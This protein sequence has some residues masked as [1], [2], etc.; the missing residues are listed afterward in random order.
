MNPYGHLTDRELIR[1][2]QLFYDMGARRTSPAALDIGA[3]L[4]RRR[5][6]DTTPPPRV[7]MKAWVIRPEEKP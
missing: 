2:G 1:V 6:V 7:P 4:V 5:L 3:E